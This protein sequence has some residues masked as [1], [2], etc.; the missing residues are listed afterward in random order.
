MVCL[1][2]PVSLCVSISLSLCVCIYVCVYAY[3]SLLLYLSLIGLAETKLD[4]PFERVFQDPGWGITRR[5][6]R[7][8]D[9][10]INV[11]SLLSLISKSKGDA[12]KL[13]V[14]KCVPAF[15]EVCDTT[16]CDGSTTSA[17]RDNDWAHPMTFFS[18]LSFANPDFHEWIAE[19]V[20]AGVDTHQ[21]AIQAVQSSELVQ[22]G[23][24]DGA[25]SKAIMDSPVDVALLFNMKFRF[26]VFF[27]LFVSATS[28]HKCEYEFKHMV[29]PLP[30]NSTVNVQLPIGWRTDEGT[31]NSATAKSNRRRRNKAKAKKLKQKLNKQRIA[32]ENKQVESCCA[33]CMDAEPN[34][35]I[36]PCMHTSVC[37]ECA[38]KLDIC[39]ICRADIISVHVN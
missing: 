26:S 13:V 6:K 27:A 30:A 39:C 10:Y 34:A 23:G 21:M 32:E 2:L 5:Y 22:R 29:M 38:V 16:L 19:I 14:S 17:F 3:I 20:H 12:Y 8:D 15:A 37:M 31:R 11:A 9:G 35:V 36:M 1:S 28:N 4:S 18:L 24:L 7:R 25:V 33:I